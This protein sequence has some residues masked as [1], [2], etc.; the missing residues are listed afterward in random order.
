MKEIRP[1][2]R[3]NLAQSHIFAAEGV[4]AAYLAG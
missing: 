1:N 2:Y 4:S 3:K